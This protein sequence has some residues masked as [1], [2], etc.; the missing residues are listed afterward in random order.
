MLIHTSFL[1]WL[2]IWITYSHAT[3]LSVD[4]RISVAF[5][6]SLQLATGLLF[7]CTKSMNRSVVNCLRCSRYS[8]VN[9]CVVLAAYPGRIS[10]MSVT[11][12]PTGDVDVRFVLL[13]VRPTF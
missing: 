10:L 7:V 2:A 6:R 5:A 4:W 1:S 9:T 13:N 12:L 11:P 8:L 3:P